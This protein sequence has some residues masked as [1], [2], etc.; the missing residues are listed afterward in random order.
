[1]LNGAVQPDEIL[2][3]LRAFKDQHDLGPFFRLQR[4]M[5]GLASGSRGNLGKTPGCLWRQRVNYRVMFD[6]QV[7]FFDPNEEVELVLA[8]GNLEVFPF[9]PS[10]VITVP[11]GA[12]ILKNQET[13]TSVTNDPEE[14]LVQVVLNVDGV[15]YKLNPSMS[16]L[17]VRFSNDLAT[18]LIRF[19][20]SWA[21]AVIPPDQSPVEGVFHP[22][23]PALA[24][25]L[26][27]RGKVTPP[28]AITGFAR[29]TDVQGRYGP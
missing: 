25:W 21:R 1:V 20:L 24:L 7:G 27:V 13:Y 22:N 12:T 3:I 9:L 15:D 26:A 16:D 4:I 8:G 5:E 11:P 23:L 10:V 2:P 6:G 18:G 14:T 28:G 29:L 17:R 19:D